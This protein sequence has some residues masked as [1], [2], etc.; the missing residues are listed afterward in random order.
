MNERATY[1]IDGGYEK[2]VMAI[3]AM[4]SRFPDAAEDLHWLQWLMVGETRKVEN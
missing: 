2:V 4:K 3:E 1:F